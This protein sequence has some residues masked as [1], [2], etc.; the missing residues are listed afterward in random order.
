MKV[1]QIATVEKTSKRSFSFRVSTVKQLEAYQK[2]Y[3]EEFGVT[4]EMKD[5]VEQMLLDFIRDDKTFQAKLK[6]GQRPPVKAGKPA[7][8]T[9]GSQGENAA[10][11]DDDARA[12]GASG[13]A[14][15]AGADAGQ[16]ATQATY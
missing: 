9:G 16:A 12:A 7:G 15:G 5:L 1:S 3:E 11:A 6:A 14:A 8:D 2:A 4:V 10:D 13:T